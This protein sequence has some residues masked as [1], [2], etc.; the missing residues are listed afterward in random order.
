VAL[1]QPQPSLFI[2]G[3]LPLI[4]MITHNPNQWVIKQRSQ[5][6]YQAI[7]EIGKAELLHTKQ[8]IDLLAVE[9]ELKVLL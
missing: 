9:E 3:T 1:L 5:F 6:R 7:S 8:P 4:G 2:S